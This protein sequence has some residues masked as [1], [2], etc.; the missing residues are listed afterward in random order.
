LLIDKKLKVEIA[1]RETWNSGRKQR[2]VGC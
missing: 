1:K 2:Q